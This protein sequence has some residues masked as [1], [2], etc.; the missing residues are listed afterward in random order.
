MTLLALWQAVT[1][2]GWPPV[3]PDKLPW[4]PILFG[5]F[6]YV[7]FASLL[8][9]NLYLKRPRLELVYDPHDLMFVQDK[10]GAVTGTTLRI[11]RV[12]VV[13]HGATAQGVSV[14]LIEC[15]PSEQHAVYSGH[16]LWP[17]GQPQNVLAVTV[18]RSSP[19]PLVMF[20][21]MAQTFVPGQPALSHSLRYAAQNLYAR[22][23]VH[24]FHRI[25]IGIHGDNAGPPMDFLIDRDP[26]MMLWELR[27]L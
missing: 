15:Y 25:R 8:R 16:E 10:P 9:E 6:A 27:K 11:F 13:N 19:V 7:A 17:V 1:T 18:H 2:V 23:L 21:V 24:G 3:L 26:Q 14:K 20:E 5:V 22:P 12:G 4:T